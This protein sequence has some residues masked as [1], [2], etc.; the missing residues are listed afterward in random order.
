MGIEPSK[1]MIIYGG[2]LYNGEG[3][4]F[5]NGAVFIADDKILAAGDEETVFAAIPHDVEM[6]S[7]DTQGKVIFPGLINLHHHFY[8]ALARGLAPTKPVHNFRECLKY[9]WWQLDNALD[10]EAIQLSALISLL[11][12]IQYG[13]TTVFDHHAS[14]H[15][16][17]GS[18]TNIAAVIER[19]GIRA[20]LC[21]EISDRDGKT[22]FQRGLD[23]NLSFIAKYRDHQTIRGM[24]GLHANFTLSETSLTEIAA[25]YDHEV[26]IHIHCA[27][28]ISDV[29]FCR[30]LGYN[31]PVSRLQHY[32][33]LSPKAILAHG[34][35]LDEREWQIINDT[36]CCVI[37]NPESNMNNSVG[38]LVLSLDKSDWLG[39]GTDGMSSNLLTTL[40]TAFLLQRHTGGRNEILFKALPQILLANN[41]RF[42]ARYFDTA[43]G[44]LKPG[45]PADLVVFDYIPYTSFTSETLAAHLIFGMAN[46]R[47][48]FVMVNG[49]CL[50]DEQTFL[51]LD[52][53]LIRE[54]AVKASRRVWEKLNQ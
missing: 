45:A 39:L 35:H 3:Q 30:Q 17:K 47:A 44:T 26:G 11:D 16:I 24:L 5:Q 7:Y 42:A 41:P 20:A 38:Q 21:Y 28:D 1:P 19:A 32:G 53:E 48:A 51:T 25:H 15:D 52:E 50:Y 12:C 9:L 46:S 6:E 33:L 34:I 18:L 54:E 43:L 14:P 40:R 22:A 36:G 8:S 27:E 10:E 23:E 29:E 4:V 49:K 13:V 31:G 37:H 2:P